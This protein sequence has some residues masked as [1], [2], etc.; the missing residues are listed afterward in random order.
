MTFIRQ[1]LIA[2][3]IFIF[4]GSTCLPVFAISIPEEQKLGNQFM[5]MMKEQQVIL[6][7]PIATHMINTVGKNILAN[8]PT[9]P[10][11]FH[12][13]LVN[14]DSFNAFASPAAN[15][16]IYKG[17]FF[18]LDSTDELAG[19]MAHEIAHAVSRHVSQSIDRS[20]MV[21]IGSMA[22]M[23]AGILIGSTGGGE[24]ASALTI[25]S[26][27]A[28]QSAMLAFT[29][30]NETDADQKAVLFLSKTPYSSKGL[31]SGLI[32]MRESDYQGMEGVPDYFKTHPGTGNRIINLAGILANYK[33]PHKKKTL[34]GAFDFNMVK[35]R[36]IGLYADL[37]ESIKKV[38]RK[39]K[40]DPENPALHYGLGLLYARKNQRSLA[41]TH[42]KK[43]LSIKLFEPMILLELGRVYIDDGQLENAKNVLAGITD[44]PVMGLW[45]KYYLAIAQLE[46]GS[47]APAEK[48]LKQVI[49]IKPEAFPRAYYHLADLMSRE[50]KQA[51]SHYYLGLYYSESRDKKNAIHQ[52]RLAKE[53][54][55]DPILK[56][57]AKK[58]FEKLSGLSTKS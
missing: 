19:I 24:E 44:N 14:D 16:F 53:T 42:F 57:D 54:L 11:T 12:F 50:N 10:F 20:K 17:L 43:A 15:L 8:L 21:N 32:K 26:L 35:Y 33:P 22:G 52:L 58:R 39:L 48:N 5:K 41:I 46:S 13:Y 45:A 49:D 30:E 38:E 34:P 56:E 23:L 3:L 2:C 37:Y 27:A 25:G 36:I 47:F 6:H 31:L 7:D 40:K 18:A 28:G 29:R 1:F 9:Q 55:K 51:L 4:L